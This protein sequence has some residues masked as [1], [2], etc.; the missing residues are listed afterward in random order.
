MDLRVDV[1]DG[2]E[3]AHL[4]EVRDDSEWLLATVYPGVRIEHPVRP[5]V[6]ARSVERAR[7]IVAGLAIGPIVDR[8][9]AARDALEKADPHVSMVGT[10]EAI[11]E[12]DAALA[13][14]REARA[15]EAAPGRE[16]D[17]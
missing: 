3:L 13:A 14:M 7:M 8:F 5:E 16:G 11:E 10:R 4:V 2:S 1:I 6:R 15:I 17:R 12:F 9:L